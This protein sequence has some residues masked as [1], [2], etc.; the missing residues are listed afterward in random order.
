MAANTQLAGHSQYFPIEEIEMFI[1]EELGD[2][3]YDISNDNVYIKLT[4]E[5]FV[6]LCSQKGVYL[7]E[8]NGIHKDGQYDLFMNQEEVDEYDRKKEE[9]ENN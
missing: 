9:M 1:E 3:C 8:S 6:E 4:E 5:E 7:N 2:R